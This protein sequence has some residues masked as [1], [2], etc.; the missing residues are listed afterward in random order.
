M[1]KNEATVHI[2]NAYLALSTLRPSIDDISKLIKQVKD[3]FDAPR[4]E[5][6]LSSESPWEPL[7]KEQLADLISDD[8]TQIK[9]LIDGNWYKSLG[10]HLKAN[11]YTRKGYIEV[12]GLPDDYKFVAPKY[13][14]RRKEIAK[15]T[16]LGHH[17]SAN[18]EK[19]HEELD[20][21][22]VL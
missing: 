19:G 6:N 14:E 18:K 13:A 22:H 8:C 1:N 12:F 2:V 3:A 15:E 16:G 21:S 17:R 20:S 11:G 4:V 7:T 10:R 9:S 5:I